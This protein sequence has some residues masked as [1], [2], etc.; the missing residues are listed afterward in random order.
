MPNATPA[1]M[2]CAKNACKGGGKEDAWV[3]GGERG[4][5]EEVTNQQRGSFRLCRRTYRGERE[6]LGKWDARVE[7]E[8]SK[9]DGHGLVQIPK[10]SNR[11]RR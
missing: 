10:H 7:Q 5:R 4:Q 3:D 9:D 11:C 1:V 6:L 2:T 8:R